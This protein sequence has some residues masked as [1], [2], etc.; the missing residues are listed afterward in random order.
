MSMKEPLSP[1]GIVDLLKLRGFD[2][3]RPAKFVRHQDARYDVHDLMR[4]GWFEHY[5]RTQSRPVFDR[6]ERIVSFIGT[7]GTRGRLV[8]VYRVLGRS[9]QPQHIPSPAGFPADYEKKARYLYDLEREPGYEDLEN[10]VVIDW[11]KGALAW[12]QWLSNKE[13]VA[14]LAKGNLRPLFRDYLD[15][16]LTHSELKELY[17][18]E[19][20]NGE[21][22]ARLAAV[23]GVYLILATKTGAQYVGSACGTDGIWGRWAAYAKDGHGGNK[24]LRSVIKKDSSYPDAFSYSILQIL[25][26][27]FART[28]V[29]NWEQR[30]KEKLGSRAVGLNAN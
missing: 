30:Y 23:A 9:S 16:T 1:L 10:R 24:L 7:S 20:A 22:R 13:V 8:G 21:W 5:Q 14:L 2:A 3:D 25:P 15:F 4:R 27:S 19:D 18:N 17:V 6:C 11:G 29:L 26:K 28:E 12:V